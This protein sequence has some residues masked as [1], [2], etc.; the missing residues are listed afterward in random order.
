MALS[1]LSSLLSH[2]VDA[3]RDLVFRPAD[4]SWDGGEQGCRCFLTR[5]LAERGTLLPTLATLLSSPSSPLPPPPLPPYLPLSPQEGG[6]LSEGTLL[7]TLAALLSPPSSS[8][9]YPF[10]YSI[11]FQHYPQEGGQAPPLSSP[12]SLLSPRFSFSPERDC[13]RLR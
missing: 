6:W 8:S 9:C 3:G 5:G 11:P 2:A 12:S 1:P 13:P 4:V 7:P 10:T